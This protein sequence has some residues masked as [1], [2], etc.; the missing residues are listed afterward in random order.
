MLHVQEHTNVP[1]RL[2][3]ALYSSLETGK[4]YIVMERIAGQTLLSL[5]ADLASLEKESIVTTLRK[6]F[7]ELRRL[8]S[9]E[10]SGSLDDRYLLDEL[11]WTSDADSTIN[12]P[13]ASLGTKVHLRRRAAVQGRLLSPLLTTCPPR[14]GRPNLYTR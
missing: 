6:H 8:P 11:F 1:V 7:N 13:F 5:W 3:H 2:V 12:G 10:Y 9:P 4:K 14:R